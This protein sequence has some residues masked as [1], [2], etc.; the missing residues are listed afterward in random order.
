MQKKKP[1]LPLALWLIP[2]QFLLSGETKPMAY[3]TT[4]PTQMITPY[5]APEVVDRANIDVDGAFLWWG[6][7]L[8]GMEFAMSGTQDGSPS[9]ALSVNRGKVKKPPFGWGPGLKATVGVDYRLDG[10]NTTATYTGLFTD[11][12]HTSVHYD[13]HK[14]LANN[15]PIISI[16]LVYGVSSQSSVTCSWR[17]NFNVVDVDLARNFFISKTI[18]LRPHFGLKFSWIEEKFNLDYIGNPSLTAVFGDSTMFLRQRQWGLGIRGG[19]DT[20]WHIIK[21]FGIYGDVAATAMWNSYRTHMNN[22]VTSPSTGTNTVLNTD[23]RF[24][25]V[26]PILEV[27]LG[28]EVTHWFHNDTCLFI[29]RAGW[30]EQVW[31]NFNQLLF[32]LDRLH[33]NL[34]LHGLTVKL[35]FTF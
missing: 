30:E 34:S 5:V 4:Q 26:L 28:I 12:L 3:S 1:L 20:V 13:A 18:T 14:G 33:G 2:T 17:Q 23:E 15:F 35:G 25:E 9:T 32:P 11:R 24:F 31:S 27:G 19:F 10:W 21:E 6:S 7:Y 22:V 8:G 16:P 29:F